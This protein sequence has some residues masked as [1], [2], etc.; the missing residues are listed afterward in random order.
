MLINKLVIISLLTGSM[1]G[2]AVQAQGTP[3]TVIT[4][5]SIPVGSAVS[6]HFR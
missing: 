3:D 4:V 1:L 5:P 6:K 2:N